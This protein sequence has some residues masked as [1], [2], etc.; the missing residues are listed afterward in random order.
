MF[1]LCGTDEVEFGKKR[2]NI[3]VLA[4][5]N[6]ITRGYKYAFVGELLEWVRGDM[7]ESPEEI[8]SRV[9][10]IAGGAIEIAFNNFNC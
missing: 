3:G 10:K 9:S 5:S 6:A 1:V 4:G 2:V 7:K 8:V